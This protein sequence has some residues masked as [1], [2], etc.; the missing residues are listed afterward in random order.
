MKMGKLPF[1]A[2]LLFLVGCAVWYDYH[3]AL[4]SVEKPG[5]PGNIIKV[6]DTT[7]YTYEDDMITCTW[8]VQAKQIS[9]ALANKT[10]SSMKILWD[11]AAFVDVNGTSHRVMHSGVK[12]IDRNVSQPPSIILRKTTLNDIV[13]PTDNIYYDGGWREIPIFPASGVTVEEVQKSANIYVGRPVQILLPLEC[14]GATHEYI[15]V[16]KV[17]SAKAWQ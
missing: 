11:Q 3:V 10:E 17:L 2:I 15:F 5:P 4:E 13:V 9:F 8:L 7:A 12:Y 16:F 1:F 6:T 14:A